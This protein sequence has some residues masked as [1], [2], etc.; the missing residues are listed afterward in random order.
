[1]TIRDL[2]HAPSAR[3]LLVGGG[4]LLALAAV[5][6]AGDADPPA[7][8]PA[9][10]LVA[11]EP[12]AMVHE[13]AAAFEDE[14]AEPEAAD[15]L[16]SIQ[17]MDE[18]EDPADFAFVV[19]VGGTTYIRL[20]NVVVEADR[21]EAILVNDDYVTSAV[22]EIAMDGLP[23]ELVPWKGRRVL[24][25]GTCA[26]TVIGF[27][28]I[29]RVS[30]DPH[31]VSDSSDEDR[32]AMRWTV[33]TAFEHG[34]T[35]IAAELDRD[36]PGAWARAADRPAVGRAIAI[37]DAALDRAARGAFFASSHADLIAD[38]WR[39]A[40]QKGD[41]RDHVPLDVRVVE[42]SITGARWV[43]VH[44]RKR[45]G[46][47]DHDVNDAVTYQVAPGGAL[48]EIEADG[49][50]ASELEALVDLNGDGWFERIVS[51]WDPSDRSLV[52]PTDGTTLAEIDV[53]F[54]GCGC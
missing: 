41:W 31:V 5:T 8:A 4:A 14:L 40:E 43:Y 18:I 47:G 38:E 19:E 42:H 45:G 36:C 3:T 12:A 2:L 33:E 27:A 22:A 23:E 9:V 21:D 49:F 1:M 28:E 24:V 48:T 30:G 25:G 37:D 17:P 26:A 51:H 13:A 35:M 16:A 34:T 50:P 11:S 6:L 10:A 32:L 54:H 15:P 39:K 52:G 53:P 29:A 20:S 7:E 44:A 46:C